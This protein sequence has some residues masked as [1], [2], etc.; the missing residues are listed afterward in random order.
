M[1]KITLSLMIISL[2]SIIPVCQSGIQI[3]KNK[4]IY[5]EKNNNEKIEIK[6]NSD[7]AYF[8]QSS[9][10]LANTEND[11]VSPFM[12]SPPIF[13]LSANETF[14]LDII[15]IDDITDNEKESLYKI[16]IKSIP[17]VNGKN[18][19][20]LHIS[21]NMIYNLIY[22]PKSLEPI[23]DDLY[24]KVD[25]L[26][27]NDNELII[28]NPTPYYLT[29]TSIK[30]KDKVIFDKTKRLPPFGKYNTKTKIRDINTL[31][32]SIKNEHEVIIDAPSK[33]IINE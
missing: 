29:I 33:K 1:K 11:D 23:A 19:N 2:V 17:I 7:D 30:N 28:H 13:K 16:N 8:I 12:I 31:S 20:I 27:N 9:V 22:R 6:N 3:N 10:K 5:I 24:Y 26:R 25:I 18:E 15:K 21:L 14:F 32:Y 4:F